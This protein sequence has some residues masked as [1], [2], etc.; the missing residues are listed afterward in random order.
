MALNPNRHIVRITACI[1]TLYL[2]AL[3]GNGQ[4][5][6][7]GQSSTGTAAR[8]LP[9]TGQPAFVPLT[10]EQRWHRYLMDLVSPA[11]V[12]ESAAGAGITQWNNTPSEWGQGAT[13]YGYRFANS[14]GIHVVRA[15]IRCGTAALLNEDNRYIPSG[16]SGFG[17]RLKYALT[18]TVLARSPDGSRHVSISALA[19]FAGGAFISRAWQPSSNTHP[20]DAAESMGVSIGLAA[21]MNVAHEF[22]PRIFHNV[23]L[24]RY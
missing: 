12:I 6:G 14:F 22:F 16:A 15:T 10:K 8:G 19:G 21:G 3:P 4:T 7:D 24:R 23:L 17:P 5:T 18:S 1:G 20:S 11:N 13:G 2:L 9:S